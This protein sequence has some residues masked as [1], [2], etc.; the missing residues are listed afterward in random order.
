MSILGVHLSGP[1]VVLGAI[2]GMVYGILAVGLVLVYRS[3]RI[4]NFAHGQIGAFGAALLGVAVV[5]W[6]VPYWVAFP[7]ALAV[8]ACVGSGA[9]AVVVRRL[10][11][12]PLI[13]TVIATLGLSQF[14]GVFSLVVNSQA[15]AGQNF[16][17]P[18]GLPHFSIGALRVTSSHFAILVITPLLVAALV[19]FLQRGRTGLAMRAAAVNPDAAGMAGI[20]ANR[21]SSLSWAIAGAVSAYTAILVLP[22]RGFTNAQF[23]GPGLLL[24]ALVAAVVARMTNLPVALGAGVALGV[25]EQVLLANY[26]N[27]GLVEAVLFVAILVT[28]LLQRSR[29]GRGEDKG[30]WAAVQ[31]WAP[32][33]ESYRRV[34]VLRSAGRILLVALVAVAVVLPAFVAN[35]TAS[36]LTFIMAFSLVG[37]SIGVI[38][39]LAG[40]LS[41]GQFGL[42]GLGAT[43]SFVVTT[44]THDIVAGLLAAGVAAALVSLVI[45]LPA[46]R[47]RGLMLAV[48]TLGFAL[49]AQAWLFG[50]SWMLGRGVHPQQPR[51]L[52]INFDSGKRY[53]FFAL[54]VFLAGLW[55]A[56]NVWTGGL[57]RCLRAVRD[58][59]DAARSFT[60]PAVTRKLQGFVVAGFIAGLGGALYGHALSLLTASS[61][62]VDSSINTAAATVV[63]GIGALVGPLLGSFYIIGIPRFLPLDNAGL[64]ATSLGWLVI[65]LQ[66]PG[67]IAQGLRPVRDR[68]VDAIARRAG[69]D[70]V[71]ERSVRHGAVTA[72]TGATSR[73]HRQGAATAGDVVLEASRLTKRYG[74]LIAVNDVTLS[75]RAGETV[76]LIGP[77]GAGKTTLFELLSGFTM[78]DAG[79]VSFQ[80]VDITRLTP[81]ARGRLG[82]IRS[83]Q[84]AALFPTLTVFD[85][86]MLAMERADP[87]GFLASLGG[88]VRPERRKAARAYD[89]VGTMGLYHYRNTQIRELS[90]GTRRITEL[91]CLIALQPSVLLLDE[92]SS[93][94]AQRETEALGGLLMRIKSDLDVTLVVIEHDI[95]LLMEISDRLIAME[96]GTILVSGAPDIVRNDARVITSY[97]GGDI[98]AI[99]R[100]GLVTSAATTNGRSR[101]RKPTAARPVRPQRVRPQ[102]VRKR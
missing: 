21:M 2:T 54:G 38:T 6:H 55:L 66:L 78:A 71:A 82:L 89:L 67:G 29:G 84:D 80:G 61:F 99:A 7:G 46:L 92:P 77:N 41:L 23:L 96:S 87:S 100:S 69:L 58:N 45:G 35:E 43:A 75:V 86:A 18:A 5:R 4:I 57:G 52:G 39:G 101:G 36:V 88:A 20:V 56:R 49:A 30:S 42:A 13:M 70:P 48:T 83:F 85:A 90:T 76:G 63:G 64:A 50:Q 15:Q 26:P 10:R 94:I 62:P 16:P 51:L 37:I 14:L 93:G 65:L 31:A 60:V 8:S 9:E 95:P 102:R 3:T 81:E 34:F 25:V 73:F 24:R 74:G 59:E 40:Q 12:A 33:P 22:T 27:G 11:S 98:T 72:M 32:L 19:L 53:Y 17:Q 97:L 28:L 68:A 79:L 44:H 91:C 1:V 47:I